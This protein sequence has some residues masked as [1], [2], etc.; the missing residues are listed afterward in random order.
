MSARGNHAERLAYAGGSYSERALQ[1]L[2]KEVRLFVIK[3]APEMNEKLGGMDSDDLAQELRMQI[4]RKLDRYDPR[5]TASIKIWAHM[6][7]RNRI[8]DLAQRATKVNRDVL[9]VDRL[10][11]EA[12]LEGD[13]A[14][15][16]ALEPSA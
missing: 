2:E 12:M 9:D 3:Y 13:E 14:A 5:K 7:M 16:E 15:W 10:S 8:I 11:Y 4:W 1:A 6:V